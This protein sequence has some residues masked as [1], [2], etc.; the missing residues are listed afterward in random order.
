MTKRIFDIWLEH[1]CK[2]IS[3]GID[4]NSGI[5]TVDK[6]DKLMIGMI[7]E[8]G[9]ALDFED[10]LR[11][12]VKIIERVRHTQM[13]DI[14]YHNDVC[15]VMECDADDEQKLLAYKT[16][17]HVRIYLTTGVLL[18]NSVLISRTEAGLDPRIPDVMYL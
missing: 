13:Y 15:R 1:R 4:F 18:E 3:A 9:C 2:T 17:E 12:S 6:N 11:Q 16:M 10:K 7:D 8:F 5:Y 14:K